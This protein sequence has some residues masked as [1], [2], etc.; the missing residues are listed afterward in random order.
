[1]LEGPRLAGLT[2]P[3]LTHAT[4]VFGFET[5]GLTVNRL[6]TIIAVS[7]LPSGLF[8][9]VIV[10]IVVDPPDHHLLPRLVAPGHP[11]RGVRV[12]RVP[13]R[14]VVV[15]HAVQPRPLRQR[16]RLLGPVDA[17]PVEVPARHRQQRLLP[18]V[19]VVR[20]VAEVLAAQV[21][22]RHEADDVDV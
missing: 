21:H 6:Y 19:G 11:L 22:V 18:A 4:P 17:L 1:P 15:R 5:I 8:H 20:L 2:A 12:V 14:V 9:L 16:H 10:S 13:R 7:H 3:Y